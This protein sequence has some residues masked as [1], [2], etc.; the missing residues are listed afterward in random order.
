MELRGVFTHNLKIERLEIPERVLVVVTGPSGSGKSSLALDTLALEGQRRYL[1]ALSLSQPV[2]LPPA[3]NLQEARG[4]PPAIALPQRVPAPNP[5]STLGTVSGLWD[6]LRR[7]WA[8]WGE[9]PCPSCGYLVHRARLSELL[10]FYRNLPPGTK[11][12]IGAP[13]K[14][15]SPQALSYLLSQGFIRFWF[16]G[17][18]RDL[19]EVSPPETFERVSAV[20]DRLLKREGTEDRFIEALRLAESL[21]GGPIEIQTPEQTFLWSLK[22]RCPQ[23]LKEV[24]EVKPSHFSFNHPQGACPEC[25]GLGMVGEKICPLCEGRRL[26]PESLGVRWGGLLLKEAL[27]YPLKKWHR[28]LK[29]LSLP[30][31]YRPL[32]KPY[33]ERAL[34]LLSLLIELDLGDLTLLAPFHQLST[35]ER[36]RVEL[37]TLLSVHLSGCLL[38]L[39]EPSLGLSVLEKEKLWDL[40]SRL[41]AEGHTV[42]VVEHDLEIIKKADWVL[43]LGP[44]AGEDGGRL[45]FAGPPSELARHPETPTGA[46]LAGK[47]SLHLSSGDQKGTLTVVCGPSG[48]GKT[49]YLKDLARRLKAE[50]KPVLFLEGEIPGKIRGLV[51]TFSG[52]FDEMRR[53]WAETVEARTLGLKPAHFSPF[54]P[55]GRCPE[56]R[57]EG[58]KILKVSGLGETLIPCEECGGSGLQW[59][60]RKITYR[61]YTLPEALEFTVEKALHFFA[62]IPKIKEPLLFL[63]ENGLGYLKLGQPLASLSGGEKLR[64]RL[65]KALGRPKKFKVLLLDLPSMGL[66]LVDLEKLLALF[67]RLL[68]EGQDLILA[69]N[70]PLLILAADQI[71]FLEKGQLSFEG[72]LSEF[73]SLD[74]PFVTRLQKY[75]SGIQRT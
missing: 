6:L 22:A 53:L 29:T 34:E 2:R 49:R 11:L 63:S 46:F 9:V 16:D 74:H 31:L 5:R 18:E 58:Q 69:E 59:E 68:K 51:A 54:S 26:K 33:L 60:A 27:T 43:E 12:Q 39:D 15:K 17:K 7:L 56:C 25:E 32:V 30:P 62:R 23:C 55:E 52:V 64:L 75:A 41:V 3:P 50:G 20:V 47:R 37:A 35:G 10:E 4:I 40:L 36:K 73:L 66:H 61:G 14:E 44:G 1:W 70:H 71:R 19:S 57:G 45:L 42:L 21:S 48:S 28:F 8:E 13:L 24:P 38:I 72:P 67:Q 65:F